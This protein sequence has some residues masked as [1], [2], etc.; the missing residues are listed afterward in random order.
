MCIGS[1]DAPI[2]PEVF[3]TSLYASVKAHVD[4]DKGGSSFVGRYVDKI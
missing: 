3:A 4:S 1:A 2:L